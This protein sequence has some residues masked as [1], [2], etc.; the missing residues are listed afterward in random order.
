M[1]VLL[2]LNTDHIGY[3]SIIIL[4]ISLIVLIAQCSFPL[5]LIVQ[6]Q[7]QFTGNFVKVN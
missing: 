7:K 5:E 1:L 2:T 3:L 6:N 4:I